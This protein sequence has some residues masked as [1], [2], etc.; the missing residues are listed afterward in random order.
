MTIK[1]GLF[2]NQ[3]KT[4]C[5]IFEAGLA[6]YNI[7]KESSNYQLDYTESINADCPEVN[8]NDYDFRIVNWHHITLPISES[9]LNRMSGKKF[10]VV[11]EITPDNPKP[12]TPNYFSAFMVMDPTKTRSEKIY[13]FP[14][15]LDVVSNL[16]PLLSTDKIVIGS[17]GF[18]CPYGI[19]LEY[20]R[21][22]EVIENANIIGN[23]IVRLNFPMGDF[24]GV[25]IRALV[26]YGNQLKGVAT[27]G[28][29]VRVTYNYISKIEL[30]QWCSE[31]TINSFPYY[32]DLPGIAAVTDQA[33]SA[34]R[35]I[36]ITDCVA[37][38]HMRKYISTY[39]TQ[40]YLELIES[41][42]PGIKQMQKDWSPE[43]FR[44]Q[45]NQM[46]TDEGLG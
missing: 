9:V 5:S 20:K 26:D 22:R 11:L 40:S 6:T 30:I 35:A 2:I 33:I 36:A 16:K 18:I 13:P 15:P 8:F 32:R 25:P 1:R 27:S 7:L 19:A 42:P 10:A 34:G 23:C 45:F 28:I 21:F 29:E 3:R 4:Q 12:L 17:F 41:T 37:F 44:T 38:R 14:R 46:L 31:N 39:P 43:N 24:T